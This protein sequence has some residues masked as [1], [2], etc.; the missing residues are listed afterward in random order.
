MS[1]LIDKALT[2]V[3]DKERHAGENPRNTASSLALTKSD[4]L[5]AK[6]FCTNDTVTAGQTMHCK[7]PYKR[8]QRTSITP[9]DKPITAMVKRVEKSGSTVSTM[10]DEATSRNGDAISIVCITEV[11]RKIIR[12][13]CCYST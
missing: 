11:C 12:G 7:M 10:N 4:L 13:S 3:Q 1:T 5:V 8:N 6:E 9:L 2:V